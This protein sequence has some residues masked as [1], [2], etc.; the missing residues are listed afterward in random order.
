MKLLTVTTAL[1]LAG[2]VGQPGD[3]DL[4]GP[5]IDARP[6]RIQIPEQPDG[7]H[8]LRL[9]TLE[10][11][12]RLAPRCPRDTS[13]DSLSIAIADTRRV[14]RGSEFEEGTA[15]ETLLTVPAAQVAP[16]PVE[17]VCAAG[18]PDTP[19]SATIPGV[20]TAHA[21]LYCVHEQG[22]IVF[23]E[24][25]SLAVELTCPAAGGAR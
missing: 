5:G 25:L 14:F 19:R 23:Y 9:P 16:L 10:F 22:E 2:F 24:A 12:L 21:S 20:L 18:D 15:L 4:Q 1:W 3:G 11:P 6:A 8:M 7:R 13:V 17:N